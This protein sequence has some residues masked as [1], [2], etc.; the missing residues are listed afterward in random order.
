MVPLTWHFRDRTLHIGP[1]P[2][3]MGIVN[4][5]PDSFSDGGNFR[6]T[7]AATAHALRLITEGADILDIGGESTRPGAEPVSLADELRR[8]VPVVTELMARTSV[9]ISVDTTKAE[10]ALACLEAGAAI[11]NDVSGFRD[12]AMIEIAKMFRAGVVV[13][14]M[15]GDPTTM[16]L[17]PQYTDVVSEVT[18]YLQERLRVLGES[19]IPPEAVCL[20]PGIGFGKTLDHNLDLLANLN[21]LA[22]LGRPVC[23]GVS[24][25][26]FIGKL[27][28][29]ELAARDPGSLAIASF[30]AARGTAHMLRVHDV[31][32]ARDAA[33]LLEAIDQHRR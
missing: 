9:P 10:V 19:G 25:K 5:T 15:R 4:V 27:C 8:V 6:G 24:R 21:S 16:Q 11:V 33:I 23:L 3:V 28:G 22:G 32:G 26:G 2:L 20:D 14:H 17:N 31:A 7:A 12:P 29:R 13:M 30:A 18:D 1:R